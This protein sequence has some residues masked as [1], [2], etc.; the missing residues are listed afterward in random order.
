MPQPATASPENTVRE[1]VLRRLL[2]GEPVDPPSLAAEIRFSTPAVA[3]ALAALSAS[4]A[5]YL[6]DG[7]VT[8]AYPLSAVPTE[9]RVRLDGATVYACC[10]I[11]AL[12]VPAMANRAGTITSPCAHCSTGFTVALREDRVLS[13]EPESPVVF[14]VGRDCC[15]AGPAVLTRCPHINFFCGTDHLNRWRSA[16]PAL[17]G[18]VLT[19]A[20]AV[21]RAREIFGPTIDLVRGAGDFTV[22]P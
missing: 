2:R 17:A 4:G 14:H 19:L 11:D 22:R 7:A 18:D 12:A 16:H 13:S 5:I 1:A 6:A 21:R 8:A 20:Q 15:E 3:Q 10:A 9:H